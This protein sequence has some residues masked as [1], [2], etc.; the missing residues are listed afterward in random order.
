VTDE[1]DPAATRFIRQEASDS[2]STAWEAEAERWARWA[3]APGHD[4]YWLYHRDVFRELLPLPPART[5]DVGCGEGRLPRDM[6]A[7]GYEVAAVD[8]SPTLVG[9]AREADPH[10]DYSIAD[11]ADLPFEDATFDLVT[12]FMT[13]HDI[14]DAGAAVREATRVLRRGGVLCV[15]IIHPFASA[16]TFESRDPGARYVI[17]GSYLDERRYADTVERDGLTITFNSRHR[18]IQAYFEMLS[19]AGVV[20]DRLVEV[21]DLHDAPGSRWRRLPLFLQVRAFRP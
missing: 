20:V 10:G 7:W 2:L 14:E 15:A 13:L 12:A 11:A 17:D 21:P 1:Q 6:K 3:R 9:L 19:A 8:A 4:S 16:G 5:L 18:P